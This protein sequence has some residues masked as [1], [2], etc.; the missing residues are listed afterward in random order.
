MTG[1]FAFFLNRIFFS[2]LF[3]LYPWASLS[4]ESRSK[5]Q[6]EGKDVHRSSF[7]WSQYNEVEGIQYWRIVNIDVKYSNARNAAECTL[8]ER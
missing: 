8:K 1:F 3:T 6:S 2:F 4:C 5:A 7:R